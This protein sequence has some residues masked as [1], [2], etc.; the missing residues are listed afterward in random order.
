MFALEGTVLLTGL[1]LGAAVTSANAVI[2]DMASQEAI[3][4]LADMGELSGSVTELL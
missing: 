2:E 4:D 1:E 3:Q